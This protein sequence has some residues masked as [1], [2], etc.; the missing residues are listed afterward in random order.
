MLA[1]YACEMSPCSKLNVHVEFMYSGA[2]LRSMCAIGASHIEAV[3]QKCVH[4]RN[5]VCV[6]LIE[7]VSGGSN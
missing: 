5:V 3:V 7:S 2:T 4:R 1:F 6:L